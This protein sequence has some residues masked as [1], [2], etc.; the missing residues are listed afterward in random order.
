MQ[1]LT[2]RGRLITWVMLVENGAWSDVGFGPGSRSVGKGSGVKWC[3]A[4]NDWRP[5]LLT[6]S[7]F[8]VTV[9]DHLVGSVT[10]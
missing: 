10:Y 1:T 3:H 2:H 7:W 4:G 8:K 6:S 5:H 9:L